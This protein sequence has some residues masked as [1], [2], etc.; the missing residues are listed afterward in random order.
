MIS[1]QKKLISI[2]SGLIHCRVCRQQHRLSISKTIR[3]FSQLIYLAKWI[4]LLTLPHATLQN[5]HKAGK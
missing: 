5:N 4:P 3:N 1:K 2:F